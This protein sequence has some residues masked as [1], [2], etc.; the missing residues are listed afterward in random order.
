MGVFSEP[1][2]GWP[3]DGGVSPTSEEGEFWEFY[4]TVEGRSFRK[5]RT[6][7]GLFDKLYSYNIHISKYSFTNRRLYSLFQV[8]SVRYPADVNSMMALLI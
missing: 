2:A 3:P 4:T 5:M 8:C 6:S 7:T 1:V